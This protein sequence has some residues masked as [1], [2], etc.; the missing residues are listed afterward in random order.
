[1]FWSYSCLKFLYE[2]GGSRPLRYEHFDKLA[3]IRA[4]TQKRRISAGVGISDFEADRVKQL[5]ITGKA[6]QEL[7]TNKK[8]KRK[9]PIGE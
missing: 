6:P 2:Y 9:R 1:M 3:N 5:N 8:R 7:D 4:K